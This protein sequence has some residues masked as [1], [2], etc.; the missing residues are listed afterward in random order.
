MDRYSPES[1]IHQD[2]CLCWNVLSFRLRSGRNALLMTDGPRVQTRPT[3]LRAKH[4]RSQSRLLKRPQMYLSNDRNYFWPNK[5]FSFYWQRFFKEQS[6][7]QETKQF[8]IQ[9]TF[10]WPTLLIDFYVF[11]WVLIVTTAV[12]I[13]VGREV[14]KAASNEWTLNILI[15]NYLVG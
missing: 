8:L 12:P 9:W 10:D 5:Y 15:P 11:L 7:F 1:G 4:S 3:S 6:W 13:H 14:S 2:R